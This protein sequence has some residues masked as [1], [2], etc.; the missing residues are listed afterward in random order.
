VERVGCVWLAW[1][2]AVSS[3]ACGGHSTHG[4]DGG[5]AT[6]GETGSGGS[7]G[8]SASGGSGGTDAAPAGGSSG[9]SGGLPAGMSGSP[10]VVPAAV[11]LSLTLGRADP[12]EVPNLDGRSCSAGTAG[13]FTYVIGAPNPGRTISDGV[14][15]VSVNCTV[16]ADGTFQASG[17]GT[18]ENSKKPITF[19]FTGVVVDKNDPSKNT[20]TA[21]FF[22][23]DTLAL[24]SL[25]GFPQCTVGPVVTLKVGAILSDIDCPLI[26]SSDD[27][28]SGC[29]AHGTIAFEYCQTGEE[30]P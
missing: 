7:G 29:S 22:S 17:S 18:D 11:G 9:A 14:D 27:T 5:G 12:A 8:D 26:A 19:S 16:R 28:T 13:G 1:A 23:P 10:P 25:E 3:A 6:A 30:A 2:L 15:G 20:G 21:T 24:G 4:N